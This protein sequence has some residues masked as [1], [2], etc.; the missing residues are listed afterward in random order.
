MVGLGLANL[1]A[2]VSGTFVVN[3]S[4]TKTEIVDS[5]GGRT[6]LATLATAAVVLVVLLFLTGPLQYLPNAAL[7]T[8]VFLIGIELVD[9][10]G[11]RKIAV[12]GHRTEFVIA[13]VTAATVVG[14][15]VEQGIILAI[16]LS[17]VAHLERSYNPRNSVLGPGLEW[18]SVPAV[19]APQIEPGLVV[20][21]SA[22]A[23]TSPTRTASRS[24]SSRSRR[25]EA[26]RS[27]GSA[28][29]R[30]GSATSTTPAPRR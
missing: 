22:R 25:P 3:G 26:T 6:Q 28:W 27:R 20:Y 29:M 5:A 30:S 18:H 13:L 12:T 17:V 23:S 19:P 11:L 24:S 10:R 21:P 9:V 8:V 4:P 14:W 2:G 1:G 15:G 7:A 16:V